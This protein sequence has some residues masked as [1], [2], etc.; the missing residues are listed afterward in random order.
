MHYDPDTSLDPI[1]R[2][3]DCQGSARCG[4]GRKLR[5]YCDVVP[6]SRP[7]CLA[8]CVSGTHTLARQRDGRQGG[9]QQDHQHR[10]A[11]SE[12]S[13]DHASLTAQGS[14]IESNTSSATATRWRYADPGRASSNTHG[15]G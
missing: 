15:R 8:R 13:R 12:L 2:A 1:T 14:A 11:G 3:T 4:S 7:R 9:C 5:A 10:Q 6:S